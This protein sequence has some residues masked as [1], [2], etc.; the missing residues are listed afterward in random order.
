MQNCPCTQFHF[1][2]VSKIPR[3]ISR[4]ENISARAC[5][6]K[7]MHTCHSLIPD[8]SDRSQIDPQTC[9]EARCVNEST[10]ATIL[11]IDRAHKGR[12]R[13]RGG[14]FN[15]RRKRRNARELRAVKRVSSLKLRTRSEN[16]FT[17]VHVTA[18][19]GIPCTFTRALVIIV[20]SN[21]NPV[22]PR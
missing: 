13:I 3:Q 1:L 21:I 9:K 16:E 22:L 19:D 20:P 14:H 12:A 4:P 17:G 6:P 11:A 15:H 2:Q 8:R 18:K 7:C 5:G 10:G